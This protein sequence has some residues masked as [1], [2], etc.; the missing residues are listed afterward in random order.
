MEAL[1]AANEFEVPSTLLERQ[2]FYMMADTQKRMRSAGMDEASAMD[3]SFKLYDQF[4]PEALK[5]VKAF[6]LVKKI[7]EKEDIVVTDEEIDNHIKMIAENYHTEYEVVKHAY[8]DEERMGTIKSE[9]MQKK[10]FDFIES[11]ANIKDVEREGLVQE[12]ER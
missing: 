10:V 8:E 2:I 11:R 4:K 5:T 9:L 1:L 6:L 12:G 7:A 3:F